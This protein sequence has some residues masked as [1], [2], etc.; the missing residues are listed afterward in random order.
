MNDMADGHKRCNDQRRS[1]PASSSPLSSPCYTSLQ[2]WLHWSPLQPPWMT[3]HQVEQDQDSQDHHVGMRSS[4]H[5]SSRLYE[6]LFCTGQASIPLAPLTSALGTS[7]P[8]QSD[9]MKQGYLGKLERN[10]RRYFVL[11]A[12]SHTG[13]SRLEWYKNQEKFTAIEKSAGKTAVFGPSKQ[14][15]IYLRCCLGVS[16]IG[17]SRR[18][19]T[20]ALYAK[21]QTMVLVM[22]DQQEQDEWYLAVKKLMEEERKDEENGEGFEEEDDGYCTLPSAA[23]FKEVRFFRCLFFFL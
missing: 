23:F 13:P 2:T 17:S 15:V 1:L 21:D 19:H 22:E 9:V 7:C 16:R 8:Q 5:P 11:K 4:E 18:G 12:G 3:D 14:G 10:Q 20:V 6:E